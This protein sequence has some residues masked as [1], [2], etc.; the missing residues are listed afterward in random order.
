MIAPIR[1]TDES[2]TLSEVLALLG[3]THRPSH[4]VAPGVRAVCRGGA[5]VC[6]GRW[7]EVWAW[8]IRAGKV[9]M[10]SQCRFIAENL[11]VVL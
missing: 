2:H 11:E 7:H 1:V 5:V 8:L 6:E 9:E 10:A 3:Y 4:R